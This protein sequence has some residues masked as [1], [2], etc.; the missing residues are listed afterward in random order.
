MKKC[1]YALL[2]LVLLA[3][4]SAFAQSG[5]ELRF[6]LRS[7]PKTFNPLLVEEDSSDTVRYLTG[8]VLVR[9]NRQTQRLEPELATEWKTSKDGKTITFTL[10]QGISFS[11]G[12]P[13]SAEDVAY[14]FQQLMDPNLH[15][16]QA[17]QFRAGD[18]KVETKVLAENKIAITFG[19]PIAG[20][21]KL[22]DQIVIMSAKSPKKEMAVLGPYYVAEN[23]AGAYVLLHRNPNY[24]K[25]D[26]AGR[27]LPYI[28]S[29]R[30]DIQQNRDL[31]LLRLTRGEIHLVNII[32][33]EY[34]EKLKA[35]QPV[36]AHD[37]GPSLDSEHM[38][39]NQVESSPL[40]AY[41][42]LWFRSTN[43]R[44]AVSEAINRED[45]A[46]IAFRGHA[47]P[48]VGIV[49]PANRFWFNSKLQPHPFDQASALKRLATDGFHLQNGAL[50]DQGG[51]AVEFSII[52]NAGNKYRE[53]MATMIQQDLSVIGMK[54]NVV[55]LDFPSLI[56]RITRTFNYEAC[57]LGLVN[58]DLD[59]ASVMNVWVSSAENHQWNPNQK[60]PATAWEAEIDRLMKAQASTLD[61]TKRKQ[62]F[63]RVQ[64]IAWEQEP[65]IYLV[66]KNTLSA[67]SPV[68]KN[69]AP[70]VLRP[71]TFW[72]VEW[73]QLNSETAS[74]K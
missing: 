43:F 36:V 57:L 22:M 59:P 69:A 47:R 68:V 34:F 6:C 74:N 72:N 32:D 56:E 61:D 48:A 58:T 66:T 3:S 8:G 45:L 51:N 31:E 71:Q 4:N 50:R 7:E 1:V 73:L 67:V 38:W 39:F 15:A 62:Y 63:D 33:A 18:G 29:V 28:D 65:F 23:K 60:T 44:R 27:P 26:S 37:S 19:A 30:L 42:K 52:T 11:D 53:R 10:R 2:L 35:E 16:P 13:F 24:W 12:T 70:V 54:V 14:T 9:L 21:D 20:L 64:E 41:K 55:T 49:S 25:H 17:D 40:P 5:G 46:R